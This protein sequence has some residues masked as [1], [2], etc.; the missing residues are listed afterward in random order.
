MCS[1]IIA[2]NVR[3]I[4]PFFI[5]TIRSGFSFA[6]NPTAYCNMDEFPSARTIIENRITCCY[7]SFIFTGQY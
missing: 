3:D 7:F 2:G 1:V 4:V 5:V 6:I